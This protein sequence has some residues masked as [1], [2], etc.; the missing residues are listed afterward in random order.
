MLRFRLTHLILLALL[1]GA[2]LGAC[3]KS[4]EKT[5]PKVEVPVV[6][7]AAPEPSDDGETA[8]ADEPAAATITS[9]FFYRVTRPDGAG[10]YLLG[11][12]HM[13]ID[14]EKEFPSNVWAAR[15]AAKI[16]AVE[17]DITDMSLVKGMM[18]PSDTNLKIL[19]GDEH[20]AKLEK[21]LGPMKARAVMAMKPSAAASMLAMEG[22]PQ[23]MPMD[24]VILNKTKEAGQDLQFLELAQFQL[25]LLDKVMT[26][27]F[28]KE[29]LDN[30]DA[31]DSQK[32]LEAY[33]A[34]DLE[35]LEEMTNDPEAW[36]SEADAKQNME[37]MLFKRNED[38]IPKL[39]VMFASKSAFVAV[40]AAHL[41]GPRGLIELLRAK[42]YTV[43]RI[44]AGE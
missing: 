18:L 30:P 37:L 13:G 19:L 34:G 32:M 22:L 24:F 27:E 31:S 11:T 36:G 15:D 35:A 8:S 16:V 17:A 3:K 21:A 26:I 9:P 6:E 28:L 20:W 40:G 23:T 43:E 14:A 42:G 10:G 44:A 39:E 4:D 12:M 2:A 38:W 25:D 41:I 29:M 5:A 1:G 7:T 33:R